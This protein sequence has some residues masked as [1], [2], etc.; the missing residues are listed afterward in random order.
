MSYSATRII[1]IPFILNIYANIRMTYVAYDSTC[2]TD[3]K[4]YIYN[5][6]DR[7]RNARNYIFLK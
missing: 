7:A 6:I 2:T 1:V 5:A 3:V 4:N